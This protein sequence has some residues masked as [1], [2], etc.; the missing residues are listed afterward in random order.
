MRTLSII[1]P[2]YNEEEHIVRNVLSVVN[3]M[4][5]QRYHTQIII[6]DDGSTDNTLREVCKYFEQVQGFII[7]HNLTNLGKGGAI[8]AGIQRASGE[9]IAF[10]DADLDI[11]PVQIRLLLD[12]MELE[13]A[14][15]VIGSKLHP[16]SLVNYPVNRRVLSMGYYWFIKILFGLKCHDTQTGLKLFK[17]AA[18]KNAIVDTNGFIFDLELLVNLY[19]M[20]Y[21]IAEAPVKLK[22][23]RKYIDKKARIGPRI[24]WRMTRDTIKLWRKIK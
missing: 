7:L 2:A 8:K 16:C 14:D 5:N 12:I 9:H 20:G 17:A 24:V 15:A 4:Y 18:V 22:S 13:N 1:I 11:T 23:Q 21:K 19:K 10:I 6:V 3:S